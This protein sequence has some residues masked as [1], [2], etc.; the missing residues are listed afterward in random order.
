MEHEI[1]LLVRP[2]AECHEALI[3]E[4]DKIQTGETALVIADHDTKP[5]FYMY[6][7]E[8]QC[9]LEWEYEQKEGN[10]WRIRVTKGG[11]F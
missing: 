10:V 5:V 2:H 11:K 6:Q 8:R 7:A 1:N 3:G 9:H 4:L